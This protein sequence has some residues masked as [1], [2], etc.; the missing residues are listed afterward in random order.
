MSTELATRPTASAELA[1]FIGM[2]QRTMLDV[3]KAQCFRNANTVSDAQLAA[4][5]S[6]ARDMKVNP[7][8][9]GMCYAYPTSG[10]GIVPMIGPA[11]VYKKLMEH[12]DVAGWDTVVYPEDV[13][14]PATHATTLIYRKSSEK[15]P[16]KYTAI[17]KEWKVASNPNWVS[18]ERH[19]LGLR[20]LKKAAEQIIHGLPYDED[21]KV[22]GDMLNV[23][24]EAATVPERPAPPPRAKKGAAVAQEAAK[25]AVTEVEVVAEKVAE[26]VVAK[27][28]EPVKADPVVAA[29]APKEEPAA[30]PV[31]APE[32]KFLVALKDAEKVTV[33]VTV[34][35]AFTMWV[36]AKGNKHATVQAEVEGEFAGKVYHFGG[37]KLDGEVLVPASKLWAEGSRVKL[38]L[39]GELFAKQNKI[40]P[41]V[42][43]ISEVQPASPDVELE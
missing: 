5:I 9:P 31:P 13:T 16:I 42:V 29:P 2:E 3:L 33:N 6:I 35:K 26:P 21:D 37:A 38:T 10:G 7:L 27:E 4:F 1:S 30:A 34:T 40:L 17:L 12:P 32:P 19:M 14:L 11:G 18:R 41:T 20:S 23:T 43:E 36:T 39:L 24:P 28:P 25:A 15:Y 22:I 8:L